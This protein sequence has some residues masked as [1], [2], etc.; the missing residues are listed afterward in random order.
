[1]KNKFYMLLWAVII[2]F[3]TAYYYTQNPTHS[4]FLPCIFRTTT[5]YYCFGCGGQRAFHA[6]LHGD[7]SL[8]FR[9]NLLIYIVLPIVFLTLC[10]EFSKK[11]L[12][13]PLLHS[14]IF[15]KILSFF[16]LIFWISRNLP[17]EICNHI[18]PLF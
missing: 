16:V 13:S 12:I 9:N 18:R 3:I 6:L 15:I 11:K 4:R 5:G 1:M 8:A 14:T 17:Y 10:E 7:F 2:S